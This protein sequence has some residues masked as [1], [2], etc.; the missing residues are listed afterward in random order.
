MSAPFAFD[1][2]ASSYDEGGFHREVAEKLV[3]GLYPV[4]HP[5][6]VLDAATG[7][8]DAAI[9]AVRQLNAERV[10]AVDLS[11]AMIERARAKSAAKDLVGRI[12]WRVGPAV[13]AP[14]DE[15]SVD[16]VLCASSLHFLGLAALA[17]WLRVLR[18]GGRLAFSLPSPDTFGPSGAFAEL[19][20]ADVALPGGVDEAA[21]I[22]TAGG[23]EHAVAHR[24]EVAGDPVRVVYLCYA[25]VPR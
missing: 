1:A 19:V 12:E 13:P 20:A 21:A 10:L 5:A 9:A 8:G 7:T 15:S 14:V 6:L 17:D 22:A 2:I 3:Q 11:A 23:F 18:P 25:T 16:V 24:L 4:P